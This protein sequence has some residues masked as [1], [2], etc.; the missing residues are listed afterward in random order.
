MTQYRCNVTPLFDVLPESF[1]PV[2]KVCSSIVRFAAA[3]SEPPAEVRLSSED[4]E[5]VVSA[6]FSKRRKTLRNSLR[7][8]VLSVDEIISGR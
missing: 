3:L 5:R 7:E 4:L 2:P 1:S 6:A 8:P